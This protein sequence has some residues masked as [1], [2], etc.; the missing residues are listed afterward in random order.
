RS[1]TWWWSPAALDGIRKTIVCVCG[2][3][4]GRQTGEAGEPRARRL[5]KSSD[6]AKVAHALV[7]AASRLVST[8]FRTKERVM[9]QGVSPVRAATGLIL[10]SIALPLAAQPPAPAPPKPARQAAPVDLTGTWVSLVTEDWLNRMVT[11]PKGEVDPS[12]P[13]SAASRTAA[14]NWDPAKD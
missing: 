4:S 9:S 14:A 6:C 3:S 12:V 1:A 7:R 5:T 13:V 10:L 11:P 2:P 8:P